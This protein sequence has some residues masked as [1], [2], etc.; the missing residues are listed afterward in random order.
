LVAVAGSD[1]ETRTPIDVAAQ[2]ILVIRA[3]C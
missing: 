1:T 2:P 3:V